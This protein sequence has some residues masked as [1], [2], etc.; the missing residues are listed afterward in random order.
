M[1]DSTIY[2]TWE[3]MHYFCQIA[4]S[5]VNLKF[6]SHIKQ[7]INYIFLNYNHLIEYADSSF[8]VIQLLIKY[9]HNIYLILEINISLLYADTLVYPTESLKHKES[10][11][12]NEVFKAGHQKEVIHKNLLRHNIFSDIG[13]AIGEAKI[14]QI[15]CKQASPLNDNVPQ[16]CNT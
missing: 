12:L 9:L 11:I 16:R 8:L 14:T 13:R 6:R 10:C 2:G 7:N 4:I 3:K 1:Q 15:T 5:Y